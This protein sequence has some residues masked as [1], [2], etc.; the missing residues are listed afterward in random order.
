MIYNLPH[1]EPCIEKIEQEIERFLFE[2]KE[3]VLNITYP[4][5]NSF[6]PFSISLEKSPDYGIVMNIVTG[7]Q[8]GQ[9]LK[10]RRN[11]KLSDQLKEMTINN[12]MIAWDNRK[13]ADNE[14][15]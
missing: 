10:I 4:M 5:V 6:E 3:T 11:D 12:L 1:A 7:M 13:G 8:V 9:R 15:Q 2:P 14:I